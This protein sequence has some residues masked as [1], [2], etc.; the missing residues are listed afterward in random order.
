MRFQ[1]SITEWRDDQ[2]F[3]FITP[4]GGGERVFVH[5]KAFVPPGRRPSGNER[6][7]YRLEKDDRGRPRAAAVEY[8]KRGPRDNKSRDANARPVAFRRGLAIG[9]FT[10]LAVFT[11]SGRVPV[12]LTAW[13]VVASVITFWMYWADK[14]AA[15][16]GHWR[17]PEKTLQLLGLA[18]G[19]P[20]ALL[21]QQLLR[22]KTS[23]TTFQ[24]TFWT[25]VIVNAAVLLLLVFTRE[26]AQF[27]HSVRLQDVFR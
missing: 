17:T 6:V 10:A 8:V 19:W 20:G 25:C 12:L 4:N 15:Q 3:G 21:G 26:G 9:F 5:V 7:N 27:L 14:S 16:R 18:G 23:K 22:H 13:Y 2:G 11:I 1:G 24:V